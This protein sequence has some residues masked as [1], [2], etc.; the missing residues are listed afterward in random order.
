MIFGL[1]AAMWPISCSKYYLLLSA[2]FAALILGAS[3]SSLWSMKT[4]TFCKQP[5]L[6]LQAQENGSV[7]HGA[8]FTAMVAKPHQHSG[9]CRRA[10]CCKEVHSLL[11]SLVVTTATFGDKIETL[12]IGV[13]RR[14]KNNSSNQK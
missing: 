4:L 7:N 3:I 11:A 10:H 5:C 14:V 2:P 13:D 12:T 8:V 6:G 9:M 1:N